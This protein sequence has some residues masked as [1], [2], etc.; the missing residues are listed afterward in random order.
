M[1]QAKLEL[2]LELKNRLK[3][4]LASAKNSVMTEMKDIKGRLSSF[5]ANN[6]KAFS[7]ITDEIP[8]VGRAVGL[9]ANPYALAA[10]AALSFAVA[11]AKATQMALDWEKSMAKVNVTAQLNR[12]E[13]DKLSKNLL[14][15]GAYGSTPLEQV[16]EA[17]NV[18]ISA[19]GDTNKSL[20]LL[21]FVLKASKAGFADL[22]IVADAATGVLASSG[23]SAT[24]VFDTLFATLN[25]GKA[26][27][28]DIAQYLPEVIPGAKNA[29]FALTET[30]GAFAF[31]TAN[32]IRSMQTATGL[33]NAFKAL[34]NPEVINKF[35]QMG[36]EI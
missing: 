34:S 19:I 26:E 12:A 27:F 15:I 14:Y 7:A 4:G 8:F 23:E 3:A 30:A 33:K 22:K 20:E 11:G 36:V 13:L 6:M 29:G 31:L 5:T 32:G 25:K 16:P 9:L 18:I 2:L 17:F 1:A 28:Q 10:A 21:P 24:V 35:R